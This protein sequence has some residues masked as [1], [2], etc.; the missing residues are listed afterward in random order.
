M[1]TQL[2]SYFVKAVE[3][4]GIQARAK[5]SILTRMTSIEAK[6]KEDSDELIRM[7][8]KYYQQIF[9]EFA[10]KND[11]ETTV[12]DSGMEAIHKIRKQMNAFAELTSSRDVYNHSLEDTCKRITESITD[13][14]EVER[15]SIWLY[16]SDETAIECVDLYEKT[17]QN[18]SKGTIL[19]KKDFP[20][21]FST[22]ATQRT[23][24]AEN[25]HTHPGTFEF[26][27][28]YLKPLGINS[29]LDVPIYVGGK[30]VGVVCNE[31]T[32]AYRKWTTDEETFAYTMGNVV[33][34]TLEKVG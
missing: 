12:L 32:G 27:E 2:H 3:N 4:G 6:N 10:T 26:S 31:H 24:A 11:S 29:M 28:V 8:D 25:A 18:H 23:L 16:N 20:S 9:K 30:M 17:P 33:A 21:Y 14:M 5:L 15:A 1:G 19:Y 7:V 13:A 34:M 22:V